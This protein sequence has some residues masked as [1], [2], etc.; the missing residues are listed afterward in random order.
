ME[1]K[2]EYVG[3]VVEATE[4]GVCVKLDSGGYVT[5]DRE[6]IFV[7]EHTEYN[8]KGSNWIGGKATVVLKE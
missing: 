8:P 2:K 7:I 6:N 5:I 1:S 3:E 4:S